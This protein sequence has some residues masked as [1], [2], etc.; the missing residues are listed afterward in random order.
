M[1]P[2][3]P[4]TVRRFRDTLQ[5]MPWRSLVGYGLLILFY[6]VIL[7]SVLPVAWQRP[8]TRALLLVAIF[9]ILAKDLACFPMSVQRMR[10]ARA[11]GAAWPCYVAAL[12]PLEL[13]AFLRLERAMWR[14][15]FSWLLRRAQPVRPCGMALGYLER[16]AYGTVIYCA[17]LVLLVEMPL[18]VFIASVMTKTPHQAH[19]LHALF[20]LVAAYSFVWV[21]GDRWHVVTRGHHVLTGM[22]LELDIGARGFGSIPLDA[23]ASCE[24]L[25]ESRAAWC[26]RHRY[27]LF[28]TRKLTPCDAPNLVL[29]L[30]PGRNVRLTLLQLERGGDGPIFLYLDRPEWLS[31][32]TNPA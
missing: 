13:L 3:L 10:R 15:F 17:L 21:M 23:I 12:A 18:D 32:V 16:G 29:L 5:T 14:G 31:K 6:G 26:R 7:S 1:P 20:G 27:P 11:R 30:K 8:F 22:S 25:T 19:V 28:A 2:A 9:L 24:R 4:L